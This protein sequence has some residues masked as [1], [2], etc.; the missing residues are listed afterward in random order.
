MFL[1]VKEIRHEKLRYGLIIG[2]IVLI[3]YLMFMLMGMM[4]GLANENKAAIDS[5]DAKSVVKQKF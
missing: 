3:G 2:M 5:W 1:A 4:L